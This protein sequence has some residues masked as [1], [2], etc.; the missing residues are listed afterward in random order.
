MVFGSVPELYPDKVEYEVAG[1]AVLRFSDCDHAQFSF[2]AVDQVET[3]AMQRLTMALR[4][5]QSPM[6]ADNG[7]RSKN[8]PTSSSSPVI[9]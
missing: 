8:W 3:I 5:C 6:I 7:V 4:L 1:K 2:S 9:S